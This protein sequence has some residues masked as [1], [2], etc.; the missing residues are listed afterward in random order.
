[1]F[2]AYRFKHGILCDV[3]NCGYNSQAKNHC[4]KSVR[5]QIYSGQHFLPFGLNT[6]RH[7]VPL[8]IQSECGKMRTRITRNTETF[9][10]V[11]I[12]LIISTYLNKLRKKR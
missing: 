7:S 2:V 8:R 12:M 1:M 10:V 9:Y 11:N 6:E 5:I 3:L 4:I